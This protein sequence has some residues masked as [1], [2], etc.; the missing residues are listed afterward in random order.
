MEWRPTPLVLISARHRGKLMSFGP[1]WISR[2]A[3]VGEKSA[4]RMLPQM[5]PSRT[6]RLPQLI[7]GE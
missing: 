3:M 5:A 7:G 2:T 6:R 1:S 4:K